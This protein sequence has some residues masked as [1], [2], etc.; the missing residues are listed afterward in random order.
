MEAVEEMNRSAM[1]E[2]A[3]EQAPGRLVVVAAPVTVK[4]RSVAGK[5]IAYTVTHVLVERDA[6][7]E[8]GVRWEA[9]WQVKRVPTGS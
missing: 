6:D 2:H 1:R 4:V 8:Y 5:A 9:N 3:L 7:G